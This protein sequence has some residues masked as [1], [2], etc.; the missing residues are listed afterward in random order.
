MVAI[1]AACA[2]V[3][4]ATAAEVLH[5]HRCHKVAALV[6][7]PAR[8]PAP[9]V[10]AAPPLRVVAFGGLTWGLVTLLMLIPKVRQAGV[11]PEGEYRNLLLVLDVS[12]SM[13]LQDAG[14]TGK[15]SRRERAADLLKSFFQRIPVDHYRMSI[16]ATYTDGKPVVVGTTDMEVVHNILNDLPME[17]AFKIGPT[18]IFAGLVEAAKLARPWRPKSTILMVVSDGDTVPATGLPKLPDS[19]SSVLLVGVGDVLAG[20]SIAGHQSRQDASTLRQLAVRLGGSYHNGNEKQI[21]T[22]LLMRVT[23]VAGQSVFQRLTPREYALMAIVAGASVLAV[24]PLLLHYGGTSYTPGVPAGPGRDANVR[25][26][27]ELGSRSNTVMR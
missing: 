10:Y 17:Y 9:W 13:R 6:F 1:L 8:R 23:A 26:E 5:A 12:P 16:I 19:I 3:I 14:P 7:G 18:D 27:L 24:L 15:Q 21:P 25:P 2:A 11:I 20:R 22:D 4:L